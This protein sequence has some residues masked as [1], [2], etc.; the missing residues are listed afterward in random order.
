MAMS[1]RLL[2]H[3]ADPFIVQVDEGG[4]FQ[5]PDGG[6]QGWEG[7][8]D[9][10]AGPLLPEQRRG[11]SLMIFCARATRGLRRMERQRPGALLARRAPTMKRWSLDVCSKIQPGSSHMEE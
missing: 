6:F 10:H 7:S 4:Q 2:V 11:W 5:W 8:S 9:T 1:D 3:E